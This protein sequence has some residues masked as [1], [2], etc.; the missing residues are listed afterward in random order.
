MR[1]RTTQTALFEEAED[2]RKRNTPPELAS[3]T[4][5]LI[6]DDNIGAM[7]RLLESDCL[8]KLIYLDPPYNT[9]RLRG[10]RKNFRD[11]IKKE[12][13]HN[14]LRVLQEAHRLL[15][16]AGFLAVSINQMELFNLKTVLDKVFGGACLVGLFPVKIRHK[17]RQLMINATFHD[18][19]E[20]LLLYRKRKTTRLVTAH[21]PARPD[22]FVYSVKTLSEP[23]DTRSINGKLVEIYKPGQYEIHRGEHNPDALRRYVI[24]RMV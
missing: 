21:K 23:A 2:D 3:V 22:M 13:Q 4:Y 14:I 24:G 12:W 18:L 17:E 9:V 15:D 8:A 19:F 16:P 5:R 6:R 10:A 20:Y 7:Q 11:T 1:S